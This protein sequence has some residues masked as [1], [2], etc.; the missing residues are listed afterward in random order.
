MPDNAGWLLSDDGG[1]GSE[2][3]LASGSKAL[4]ASRVW[5][6]VAARLRAARHPDGGSRAGG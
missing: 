2:T 5:D 4:L 6:A 3:E 1:E